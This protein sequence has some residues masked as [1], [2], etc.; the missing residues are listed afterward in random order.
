MTTEAMDALP[1]ED[2]RWTGSRPGVDDPLAQLAAQRDAGALRQAIARLELE[3]REVLILREF[4]DLSYR[5]I[6]A[7]VGCPQGTVMSRLSR[8]RDQLAALLRQAR[9]EQ[10]S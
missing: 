1:A 3:Q 5:Q 7:I 2:G 8:A 10:P 6:A 4:E 9:E